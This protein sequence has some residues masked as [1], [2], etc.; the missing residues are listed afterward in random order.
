[1][2]ILLVY[3]GSITREVP[4]NLL[5]ISAV[6]E[7]ADHNTKIFEFTPY[8]NSKLFNNNEKEIKKGF[9]KILSDFQPNI[10][11]FS[12]MTINFN[13]S[14]TLIDIVKK[15]SSAKVICGGIHPT[16]APEETINQ[17]NVDFI[18]IGEGEQSF[19][20]LIDSLENNKNLQNIEGIWTKNDNK[21][22]RNSISKLEEDLDN[23]PFPNREALPD[24]YYVDELIGTNIL[25]SRGCPYK[26]SFCQ[27]E[28]LMKIYK[29]KGKFVRYRSLKNIFEEIEWLKKRYNIKKLYFS[30]ETFTLNKKRTL[31]FLK[32]YKKKFELP[33]MCQ[34]R[35]DRIDEEIIKALKE[36]GC[37][38]LS[39][40][41]ESGN[42]TIRNKILCKPYTNN[43][44]VNI[45]RLAKKY[46]LKI[47]SFNMIGIPTETIENIFETIELNKKL[48]PN[49]I[50][51]T[52][53]TPFHGT[54]L[55]EYCFEHKLVK[56]NPK[57]DTNYYNTISLKYKNINSKD[58]IG[59]QGF[60]DWYVRLPKKYYK[61]IDAL[62]ILYQNLLPSQNTKSKLLERYR[63]FLIEIVYQSKQFLP[64]SKSYQ[65]S[66]R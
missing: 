24:K 27:N 51:C 8:I 31:N 47:Q 43:Q 25:T 29:N 20:Q 5:Y 30:D 40:A 34:T 22:Y 65:I 36:A 44:I 15:Q 21:I 1:M 42:D 2:K 53:Y 33:F 58:L 13:I 60:F 49:R 11:G 23:I 39:L 12:L 57:R 3:P 35:I 38:H 16:I 37:Y 55:G 46:E 17:K 6:L 14:M 41:I 19:L 64:I 32:E 61:L 9:N 26:C 63:N 18:C 54:S 7:K 45:F 56:H 66:K 48:Q 59:Y 10:V 50:L 4:L 28:Y 52:I 62:R